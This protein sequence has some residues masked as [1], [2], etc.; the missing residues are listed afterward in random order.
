MTIGSGQQHFNVPAKIIGWNE[1]V[2]AK[3]EILVPIPELGI[4]HGQVF[5][6][7]IKYDPKKIDKFQVTFKSQYD[8]GLRVGG[9][10]LLRRMEVED[11]ENVVAKSVDILLPTPRY[12]HFALLPNS[13]VFIFPPPEGTRMV[14]QGGIAMLDEAIQIKGPLDRALKDMMPTLMM[15][16]SYGAPGLI[17]TGE[18]ADGEAAEYQVG[19]GDEMDIDTIMASL[20]PSVAKEDL[21]WIGKGKKPWFL[22]PFFLAEIDP[23]RESRLSAQRINISYGDSEEPSWTPCSCLL[24]NPGPGWMITD[25][26]PLRE[27][28]SRPFLLLDFLDHKK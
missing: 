23:D 28:D 2:G 8:K 4:H 21:D 3:V 6:A 13:A 19:G 25:T 17:L 10:V 5:K 12:G 24:R 20:A 22:I 16:A 26:T 27:D 1:E 9:V 11:L 15:A 14:K 7:T 18:T